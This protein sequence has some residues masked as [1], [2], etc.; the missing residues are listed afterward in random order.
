MAGYPAVDGVATHASEYYW[1]S[2][3]MS[4]ALKE[5]YLMHE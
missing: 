1:K 2:W 4:W 3:E 5:L